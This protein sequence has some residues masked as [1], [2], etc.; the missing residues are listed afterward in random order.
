VCF[1][2]LNHK[3]GDF[4][5]AEKAA[6]EVLALPIYPELRAAQRQYVV[7]TVNDYFAGK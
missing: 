7:D 5:V 6:D 4:P 1:S 2:Y 3:H